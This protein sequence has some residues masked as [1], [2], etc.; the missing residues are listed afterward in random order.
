ML[1]IATAISGS[2]RKQYL[3]ELEEY[4]KLHKKRVK[5]Y[6]VG[7]MLFEQ[8]KKIG[9][10]ITP[11]N[12]LN[13]NPFVLNALRSAVF[14]NI[15]ITLPDDLKKY[16]AVVLSI[17]SFFYWK[18]IFTRAYDR[19]YLKH[20]NADVFC[21][22]IDDSRSIKHRLDAKDQWKQE[23]LTLQEI[24][25]WQNVEVE[26]TSSWADIYSKTF[27]AIPVGQ[28]ISTFYKIL[29]RPQQELIYISMPITHLQNKKD[30]RRV[31]K[32]IEELN[33]YFTVFDPRVVEQSAGFGVVN[34]KSK[35]DK[36]FFNQIVN[37]DFYWFVKQSKK[38]IVFFPKIVSSPGVIN[39]LREAHETNKTVWVIYPGKAG[40]PFLTYF[41][42]R[43]FSNEKEFFNFI[44]K[45]YKPQKEG[46][47][48]RPR[49]KRRAR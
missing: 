13:T 44:K 36:T 20:L 46:S 9:V 21:A 10:P 37:R 7:E 33:R 11:E 27:Y 40:S 5:V 16:D 23:N 25:L 2:G 34:L 31:D 42:D 32:F 4:A 29:F 1:I 3:R 49:K 28:P 48:K 19:F 39:E 26:I 15:L 38:V 18:K 17:H 43:V 22:F 14:E 6:H 45:K 8:A 12:V 47:K 35:E 30:Q 24:L 41:S